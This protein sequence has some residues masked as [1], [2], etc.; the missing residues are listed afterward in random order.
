MLHIFSY[1]PLLIQALRYIFY[2]GALG[3]QC[4][5]DELPQYAGL[6]YLAVARCEASLN[7]PSGEAW[8]LIK[9][10]R[11][12]IHAHAQ[13]EANSL[14]APASEHLEVRCPLLQRFYRL[15]ESAR[16]FTY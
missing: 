2:T 5:H 13:A 7:N 10:G 12:F 16:C 8:A 9:A 3:V 4:E 15:I 6:C 11:K 1:A 14:V